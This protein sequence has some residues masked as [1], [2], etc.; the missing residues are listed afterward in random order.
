MRALVVKIG[1]SLL[2]TGR[3]AEI[4]ALVVRARRPTVVVPGGGPFADAVREAQA[5]FGF[6][7]KLAHRMALLA[8]HQTGLLMTGIEPRLVAAETIAAMRGA[9]KVGRVAVWLP[10]RLC[11]RDRKIPC[12]WSITSDGLA[13]RLAERL[14]RA[15]VVLVK[16]RTVDRVA[17]PADLARDGVVDPVFAEIQARAGLEW[18]VLGPGEERELAALLRARPSAYME[19]PAKKA[20]V[21]ASTGRR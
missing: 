15:P 2:E 17:S 8:M 10:A 5:L 19:R 7:D 18:A 4:L 1:G 13:A 9:W 21:L 12:D 11:E 16:S 3:L 14:G 6:S 20:A